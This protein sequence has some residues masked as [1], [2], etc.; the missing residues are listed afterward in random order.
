LKDAR[1]EKPK[2]LCST[3][4]GGGSSSS[5]SSSSRRIISSSLVENYKIELLKC[6]PPA[7]RHADRS[8]S[9]NVPKYTSYA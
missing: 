6:N 5:S 4:G 3:G 8:S 2:I 1:Y 9:S 7:Q